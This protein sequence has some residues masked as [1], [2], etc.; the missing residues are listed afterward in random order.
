MTNVKKLIIE[1][2]QEFSET[3]KKVSPRLIYLAK[4]AKHY[5]NFEEFEK[6]YTGKNFHGIYWHLT[7]DPNFKINPNQVPT[8]LSS[9]SSGTS[10]RGL[11]VTT[12]ISNW[13]ATFERSRL[14]VAQIDLSDLKPDVDYINVKRGFGHEI[15]VF[16]PESAKVIKVLPIKKALRRNYEDYKSVLPSNSEQLK[17]LWDLVHPSDIK[18]SFIDTNAED[19]D[20][21]SITKLEEDFAVD[22]LSKKLFPVLIKQFNAVIKSPYFNLINK[23]FDPIEDVKSTVKSLKKVKDMHIMPDM[24]S[25][26]VVYNA[27]AP[28]GTQFNFKIHKKFENVVT[29]TYY[30]PYN[31]VTEDFELMPSGSPRGPFGFDTLTEN[32]ERAKNDIKI[33]KTEELQALDY[34]GKHVIWEVLKDY[35]N[36]SIRP[37]TTIRQ[38]F[39]KLHKFS[40]K[41]NDEFGYHGAEYRAPLPGS[42]MQ[43]SFHIYKTIHDQKTKISWRYV[44]KEKDGKEKYKHSGAVYAVGEDPKSLQENDDERYEN[45]KKRLRISKQEEEWALSVISKRKNNQGELIGKHLKKI[46]HRRDEPYLSDKIKFLN[47]DD[48]YTISIEKDEQ[49]RLIYILGYISRHNGVYV[50]YESN[51]SELLTE[52]TDW[53][54]WEGVTDSDKEKLKIA[55]EAWIKHIQNIYIESIYRT[56]VFL[57]KKVIDNFE[58]TDPRFSAKPLS[59]LSMEDRLGLSDFIDRFD[60]MGNASHVFDLLMKLSREYIESPKPPKPDITLKKI[61]NMVWSN[62]SNKSD[63]YIYGLEDMK[64]VIGFE[65]YFGGYTLN[66]NF[67]ARFLKTN[68]LYVDLGADVKITNMIEVIIQVKKALDNYNRGQINENSKQQTM[69][70]MDEERA[71]AYINRLSIDGRLVGK[72]LK[73][74]G[75]IPSVNVQVS[76]HVRYESNMG[77][78]LY[79]F[80]IYRSWRQG[81]IIM[82]HADMKKYV[83]D[84][85]SPHGIVQNL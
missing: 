16:K 69:S 32:T 28:T 79:V 75:E 68:E 2:L 5:K 31:D 14:Y 13:D 15:F 22:Y 39:S 30:T 27:I 21:Y 33:T 7:V 43:I 53:K 8:D 34:I 47:V 24:R 62:G 76:R 55:L 26:N 19:M 85:P 60:T 57:I 82:S 20:R 78:E 71:V 3:S 83:V 10:T 1:T 52:S 35:N 44:L 51:D 59:K 38:I 9:L 41:Q 12:H 80:D 40:A 73:K 4:A 54:G 70:K 56:K 45:S 58:V 66:E 81:L 11:M 77:D 37:I 48:G 65:F 84:K 61:A 74:V 6:D 46:K 17:K 50:D 29:I 64:P 23:K 18:E 49:G 42:D 72:N 36:T 67:I 63:V 25:R